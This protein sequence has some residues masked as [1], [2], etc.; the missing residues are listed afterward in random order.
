MLSVRL[1]QASGKDNAPAEVEGTE[2]PSPFTASVWEV[3]A[4]M[5]ISV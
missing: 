5:L 1:A 2:V 3:S 4:D